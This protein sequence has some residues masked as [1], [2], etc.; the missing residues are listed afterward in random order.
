MKNSGEELLDAL[1]KSID[2]TLFLLSVKLKMT[3]YSSANKW[4]CI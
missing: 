4:Y 2:V 1:G 3:K